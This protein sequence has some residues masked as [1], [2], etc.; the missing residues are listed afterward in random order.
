MTSQWTK[1]QD[2]QSTVYSL[3]DFDAWTVVKIGR[4]VYLNEVAGEQFIPCPNLRFARERIE[5][6]RSRCS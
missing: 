3:S 1:R 6:K 2:G 4:C 5:L